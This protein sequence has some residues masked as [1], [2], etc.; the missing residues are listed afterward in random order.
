MGYCRNSEYELATRWAG[1]PDAGKEVSDCAAICERVGVAKC[2]GY[3]HEA[4][5]GWCVVYGKALPAKEEQ[6]NG[7]L[8]GLDYYSSYPERDDELA[9]TSGLTGVACYSRK[10][11]PAIN[12]P[13][14]ARA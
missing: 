7:K 8:D 3:A 2:T 14:G 6:P 12:T 11:C 13:I 4:S 10:S 1:Y 5:S 9:K